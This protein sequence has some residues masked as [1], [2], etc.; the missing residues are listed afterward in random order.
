MTNL[1]KV[2][3][4]RTLIYEV[5]AWD[6]E[7]AEFLA[8]AKQDAAN[9]EQP[10]DVVAEE[11]IDVIRVP[12]SLETPVGDFISEQTKKILATLTPREEQVLRMRFGLGDE[13]VHTLEEVG[14]KFSVTRE[15]I[16]QIEAKALRKLRHLTAECFYRVIRDL[17]QMGE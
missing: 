3:I 7:D 15:R 8:K 4:R 16:R 14:Q 13:S 11:V 1:Y 9:N 17:Q 6:R 10:E 12:L 5:E 2:T